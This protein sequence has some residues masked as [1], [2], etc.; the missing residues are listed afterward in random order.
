MLYRYQIKGIMITWLNWEP[1]IKV[2]P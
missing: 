1:P 2:R